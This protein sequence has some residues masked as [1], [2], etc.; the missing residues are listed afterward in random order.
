M[1][2][3]R[4]TAVPGPNRRA[5]LQRPRLLGPLIDPAGPRLAIV[6]APAGSGKTTL[7]NHALELA[8]VP[9]VRYVATPE[10][11]DEA[12]LVRS[13][14]GA[15]ETQLGE[16]VGA[17]RTVGEL[18]GN[19]RTATRPPALLVMDDLHELA[20]TD[21][22]PALGRLVRNCPSGMRLILGCRRP[23]LPELPS[24][25]LSPE[26]HEID[27][28][29]LRFRSWEVEEL[30]DVVHHQPLAPESAAALARRTGGWAAGLALFHLATVHR[31][32]AQLRRAVEELGT[33]AR[34][35][36]SYLASNVLAELPDGKREFLTRTC[37]LGTLTGPLC[38]E[39]LGRTHSLSVLEEFAE[40]QLFTSCSD[41]G[42]T[43]RYHEV[44]QSHLE[45]ALL[46]ELGPQTT[47]RWYAR[48]ATILERAG[49]LRDALRAYA[50]AEDWAS[51]RRL[52]NAGPVPSAGGTSPSWQELLPTAL[53]TGD[54][55][56]VLAGARRHLRQGDLDTAVRELRRAGELSEEPVFRSRVHAERAMVETWRPDS[57]PIGP[58]AEERAAQAGYW[59]DRILAAVHGSPDRWTS[60]RPWTS[61]DALADGVALLLA[62]RPAEA[63][64]RFEAGTE[65]PETG[66]LDRAL[67]LGSLVAEL[68]LPVPRPG[69][70]DRL[71][72]ALLRAEAD[73]LPW[74]ARQARSLLPLVVDEIGH[75][76]PV[77]YESLLAE[78]AL[79]GDEWGAALVQLV[80]G[81]SGTVDCPGAGGAVPAGTRLA[82]A[83][84]RFRR[85]GAPVLELWATCA[86]AVIL[87]R[88]GD[89]SA[90]AVGAEVELTA[91]RMQL[92]AAG[93]I[94]RAAAA[95]TSGHGP[96]ALNR[97]AQD[98]RRS[99]AGLTCFG[100]FRLEAVASEG[101]ERHLVDVDD[102][103]PRA[104][105]LLR[106]LAVHLGA[107]VHRERLVDVLWPGVPLAAGTRS[108]Q[109]AVSS[110]RKAMQAAGLDAAAVLRR[111]ADAYRLELPAGSRADL[112]DLQTEITLADAARAEGDLTAAVRHRQIA[113]ALYTG[114]LLPEDGPA[115]WVVDERERLRLLATT[116]ATTLARDL[117]TVGRLQEA[118]AAA[119]RVVQI[120]PW[121][122]LGWQLLAE[123]YDEAGDPGT[124]TRC[125]RRHQEVARE[126]VLPEQ[127]ARN[128]TDLIRPDPVR[129]SP[130]GALRG[131]A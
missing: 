93:A 122:D 7:L 49:L 57:H 83:E 12:A 82:D 103:R 81:A 131:R 39:L 26:V 66:W 112:R 46:E 77:V 84:Q 54:P 79:H 91:R 127:R 109:V 11:G 76:A 23:P 74:L 58:V 98:G 113:L 65:E 42:L 110:V 75:R 24:L 4:G 70:R 80:A 31:T 45:V 3:A 86:R 10:D 34:L 33:G 53:R 51:V 20:G 36:R 41:Q 117:R 47:A 108:L 72:G 123:L 105:A 101:E 96:G 8:G 16:P 67:E 6:S 40:A 35:L 95:A 15:I 28:E 29:D 48:S 129:G 52:L 25:R 55:W 63:L 2:A 30:F 21:A 78:C 56:F 125:R 18:L 22:Q 90:Q 124:A 59:A 19:L 60:A 14:R 88:G 9:A 38:D 128:G 43:F 130:P 73:D 89:P 114:E 37:V 121:S 64:E 17:A 71:E 44:L 126:L 115:E 111:H 120:D 104:R 85:L 106:Y 1:P 107:D 99:T 50:H 119:H 118:I 5:G 87:Q 27:G 68:L 61:A 116:A 32:P 100:G 62:G 97:A 13:L 92:P 69:F 102:V 94:V